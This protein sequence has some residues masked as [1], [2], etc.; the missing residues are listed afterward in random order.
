M[1]RERPL[2]IVTALEQVEKAA[3][4]ALNP[5]STPK[6]PNPKRSSGRASRRG[7]QPLFDANPR[8]AREFLKRAQ[9][10]HLERVILQLP[11]EE[12]TQWKEEEEKE[13][14]KSESPV[15]PPSSFADALL[16]KSNLSNGGDVEAKGER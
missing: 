6:E 14:A 2:T 7:E 16:R 11:G 12:F 4:A 9:E 15:A 3:E 13:A 10:G 8:V 5:K 1:R